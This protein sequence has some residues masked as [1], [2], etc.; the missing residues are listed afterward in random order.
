MFLYTSER[1]AAAQSYVYYSCYR[2]G[3]IWL[4][5]SKLLISCSENLALPK[6][7]LCLKLSTAENRALPKIEH[8]LIY[9]C[10]CN[11]THFKVLAY[12]VFI[13]WDIKAKVIMNPILFFC[14][15]FL[16]HRKLLVFCSVMSFRTCISN[17]ITHGKSACYRPTYYFLS[18]L[19]FMWKG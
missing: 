8:N 13:D 4:F 5:F 1:L 6:A 18:F 11:G 14:S 19:S 12:W 3:Q 7:E 9:N 15:P 17:R 10:L 16:H 2:F